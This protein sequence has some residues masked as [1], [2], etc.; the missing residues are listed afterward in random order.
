MMLVTVD[1]GVKATMDGQKWPYRDCQKVSTRHSSYT[2]LK[3]IN[4]FGSELGIT[5]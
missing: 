1:V 5:L 4:E 2:V 3:Y